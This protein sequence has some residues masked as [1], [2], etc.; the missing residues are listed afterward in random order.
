M[1]RCAPTRRRARRSTA[2]CTPKFDLAFEDFSDRDAGFYTKINGN[3]NT[4]MKP[5]DF[6]RHLLYAQTFV[7][8][9][10]VRI[11]AWQI[12]L[13]NTLMRAMN[14]TWDHFQDNRVQWLLGTGTRAR[15]GDPEGQWEHWAARRFP[16]LAFRNFGI[17]GQRTDEIAERFDEAVDGADVL[18]VQGGINDIAQGRD[19]GAA[20]RDLRALV[21]RG[22]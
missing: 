17:W 3:P 13:G 19:L 21:E 1:R 11:V 14:N 16:D 5:A 4:W 8:L 6:H 7:R 2:R 22:L 20:A 9:A 15:R 12:P 18:V 10:G